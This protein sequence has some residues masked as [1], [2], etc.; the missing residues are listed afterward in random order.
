MVPGLWGYLVFFGNG[1]IWAI[2]IVACWS[3]VTRSRSVR[4]TL[5]K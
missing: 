3:I 5:A 4:P 2:I 1:I